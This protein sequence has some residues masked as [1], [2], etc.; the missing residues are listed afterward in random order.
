MLNIIYL[1]SSFVILGLKGYSVNQRLL[2]NQVEP[3]VLKLGC[4]KAPVIK[5][6]SGGHRVNRTEMNHSRLLSKWLVH[7]S[8]KMGKFKENYRNQVCKNNT[9]I[10]LICHSKKQTLYCLKQL[11]YAINLLT[12]TNPELWLKRCL[13]ICPSD[14]FIITKTWAVYY[15]S[16]FN[17][18]CC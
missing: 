8:T 9:E 10:Y 12:E 4:L 2:F 3:S 15:E 1:E 17:I 5:K 11:Q 14:T 13:K 18:R 6:D 16:G 7:P